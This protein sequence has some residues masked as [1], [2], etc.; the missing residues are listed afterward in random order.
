MVV[1][2]SPGRLSSFVTRDSEMMPAWLITSLAGWWITAG[3][4]IR[5]GVVPRDF[6]DWLSRSLGLERR[7]NRDNQARGVPPERSNPPRADVDAVAVHER[8]PYVWDS[9]WSVEC[10]KGY[11]SASTL[12][13]DARPI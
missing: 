12:W 5:L 1:G 13:T 10:G 8:G 2:G 6:L 11:S 9:L 3:I 7:S 4:G